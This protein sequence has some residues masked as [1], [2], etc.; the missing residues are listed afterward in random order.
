MVSCAAIKKPRLDGAQRYASSEDR[1]LM[2]AK[3]NAIIRA[4]V[5]AECSVVVLS[6]FG[7]GALRNAPQE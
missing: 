2:K 6:A 5:K 3:V 7:R 1:G 4:A